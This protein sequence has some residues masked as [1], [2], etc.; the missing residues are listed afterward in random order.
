MH[1][2]ISVYLSFQKKSVCMID[3]NTT[4][5]MQDDTVQ[6]VSH[7]DSLESFI[8]TQRIWGQLFDIK[9]LITSCTV[10]CKWKS[11]TKKT[12]NSCVIEI[13]IDNYY[14]SVQAASQKKEHARNIERSAKVYFEIKKKTTEWIPIGKGAS[15]SNLCH[16]ATLE[17]TKCFVRSTTFLKKYWCSRMEWLPCALWPPLHGLHRWSL[18]MPNHIG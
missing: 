4:L 1:I 10:H 16:S 14:I 5:K 6:W 15:N 2:A 17:C 9:L 11:Q 8:I 18:S 3:K 7:F 13:G 12:T